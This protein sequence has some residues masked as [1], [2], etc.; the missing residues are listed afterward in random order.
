VK[1][2]KFWKG[3]LMRLNFGVIDV[4]TLKISWKRKF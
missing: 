3:N 1:A 2:D 4:Y